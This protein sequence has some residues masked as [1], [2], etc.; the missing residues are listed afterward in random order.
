MA[1]TAGLE[2]AKLKHELAH[3]PEP[4]NA[5]LVLDILL[6]KR[7][8]IFY[9]LILAMENFADHLMLSDVCG[10]LLSSFILFL[11]FWCRG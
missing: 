9:R 8:L 4:E 3:S 11:T 7:R 1:K 6:G 5:E 10:Q 2:L